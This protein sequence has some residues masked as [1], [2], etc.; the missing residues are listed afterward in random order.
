M[1][2]TTESTNDRGSQAACGCGVTAFAPRMVYPL[3]RLGCE[4]ANETRRYSFLQKIS[5]GAAKAASP[6]DLSRKDLAH[7]LKTND[8]AAEAVEWTLERD[9]IPIYIIRPTGPFAAR[10]YAELVTILQGQLGIDPSGKQLGETEWTEWVAVPGRVAGSMDRTQSASLPVLEPD[11]RGLCSWTTK[12]LLDAFDKRLTKEQPNQKLHGRWKDVFGE[13]LE[14]VYHGMRNLGLTP[15]DRAINHAA[16]DTYQ[17]GQA[18][19]QALEKWPSAELERVQVRPCEV[20]HPHSACY[21]VELHFTNGSTK[22]PTLR[23]VYRYMVDVGD[24][25][26]VTLGS[27]QSWSA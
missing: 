12:T 5:A 15:H 23:R 17:A 26:P 6:K 18:I 7:Y 24:V 25:V 22:S 20:S 13:F 10:I 16:T 4:L 19:A 14:R 2:E 8:W 3:G 21:D 9:G 27:V 1:A 11:L